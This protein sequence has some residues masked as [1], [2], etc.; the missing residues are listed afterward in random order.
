M[1]GGSLANVLSLAPP[2]ETFMSRLAVATRDDHHIFNKRNGT[3]TWTVQAGDT[4]NGIAVRL[5]I[6]FAQ[7]VSLN[8]SVQ[9]NNLQIGQVLNIPCADGSTGSTVYTIVAGDTGNAISAA[10]GITFDQLSSF[11]PGVNWYNLQIGQTL[12]VPRPTAPVNR[13]A[14]SSDD[15]GLDQ[16]ADQ[17]TMETI[18]TAA[19]SD[20]SMYDSQTTSA[21]SSLDE[22]IS[23]ATTSALSTSP[24]DMVEAATAKSPFLTPE[25]PHTSTQLDDEDDAQAIKVRIIRDEQEGG[26][27]IIPPLP[28]S[29]SASTYIVRPGD[30]GLTIA[31]ALGIPFND[32]SNA[33]PGVIWTNLQIGQVLSLPLTARASV[34]VL[35]GPFILPA[36]ISAAV[37]N[38]Y[39]RDQ[40]GYPKLSQ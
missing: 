29:V 28:T 16:S 35:T 6:Q 26:A 33:N 38:T 21:A 15:D 36:T 40:H 24:T 31:A 32:L 17:P 19:G 18:T 4:G 10:Y 1:R 12:V 37:F 39:D 5:S 23:P 27:T 13:M 34:S 30:T 7:L 25:S 11:N 20:N 14:S 9:W 22:N 2:P 3:G 8:P